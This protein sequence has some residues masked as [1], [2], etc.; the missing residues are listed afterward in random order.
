MESQFFITSQPH[1]SASRFLSNA[2]ILK[3]QNKENIGFYN[4]SKVICRNLITPEPCHA[5]T[6]GAK[7][8][9]FTHKVIFVICLMPFC[10]EKKSWLQAG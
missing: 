9:A 8:S 6:Q 2:L 5:E 4:K 1:P 10:T 7:A 3:V